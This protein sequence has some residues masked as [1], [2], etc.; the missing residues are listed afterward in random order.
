MDPET[1]V[2]AV[3]NVG[4]RDGKIVRISSAALSGTATLL[5]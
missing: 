5:A 3:R 4:I 2:D 1:N